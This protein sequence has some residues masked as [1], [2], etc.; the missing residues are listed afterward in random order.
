MA[1]TTSWRRR[2][3]LSRVWRTSVISTRARSVAA[4]RLYTVPDLEAILSVLTKAVSV[5]I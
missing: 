2:H 4:T 5:S 1:L 3:W